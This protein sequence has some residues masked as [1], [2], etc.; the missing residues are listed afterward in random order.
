MYPQYR[1][2]HQSKT[3]K[4]VANHADFFTVDRAFK[5]LQNGK[6]IL[7]KKAWPRYFVLRILAEIG[8][9]EGI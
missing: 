6:K 9:F 3:S 7:T 8:F 5:A 1:Y 4:E 2:S